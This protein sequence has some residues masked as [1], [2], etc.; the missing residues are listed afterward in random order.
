L[1][2]EVGLV[3]GGVEIEG[4][5]GLCEEDFWWGVG[6]SG[7]SPDPVFG[8]AR[9]A[10]R[11]GSLEY[12][13][14]TKGAGAATELVSEGATED[15]SCVLCCHAAAIDLRCWDSADDLD[16][17]VGDGNVGTELDVRIKD[18]AIYGGNAWVC[19]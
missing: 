4:D 2:W 1:V 18:V 5:E 10:G 8:G 13:I 6:D 15:E 19:G 9:G 17:G 7:L 12:D 14:A 11:R 16:G 3:R